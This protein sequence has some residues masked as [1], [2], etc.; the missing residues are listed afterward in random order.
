M[1]HAAVARPTRIKAL[2]G[3]AT[4]ADMPERRFSN[5]PRE[6]GNLMFFGW[7]ILAHGICIA[8]VDVVLV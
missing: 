8:F 7:L 5:Y 2:I 1:L 4:A 3:I 6:V